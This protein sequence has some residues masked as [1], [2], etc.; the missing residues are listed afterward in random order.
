MMSRCHPS[1]TRSAWAFPELVQQNLISAFP[2]ARSAS[3]RYATYICCGLDLKMDPTSI[4]M[5]NRAADVLLLCCTVRIT[6]DNPPK[7]QSHRK[8]KFEN[9]ASTKKPPI[10]LL[11]RTKGK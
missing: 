6:F 4:P 7:K 3:V 11:C 5:W 9:S 2:R 10:Y 8:I 1:T